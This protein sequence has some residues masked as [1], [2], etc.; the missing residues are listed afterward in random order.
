MIMILNLHDFKVVFS[1][2]FSAYLILPPGST[3]L[4]TS[5]LTAAGW[6]D[7]Y[8]HLHEEPGNPF[9]L[10]PVPGSHA[11]QVTWLGD[12]DLSS[13]L[14]G[15]LVLLH[16]Q[17]NT[18]TCVAFRIAGSSGMSGKL[19]SENISASHKPDYLSIVLYSSFLILV[20]VTAIMA[21]IFLKRKEGKDHLENEKLANKSWK[22]FKYRI[23]FT[24]VSNIARKIEKVKQFLKT[25]DQFKEKEKLKKEPDIWTTFSQAQEY[26][27]SLNNNL[28]FQW[29]NSSYHSHAGTTTSEQSSLDESFYSEN[30]VVDVA[31]TDITDTDSVDGINVDDDTVKL[32]LGNEDFVLSE[33]YEDAHQKIPKISS[34]SDIGCGVKVNVISIPSD[35]NFSY[36][37]RYDNQNRS[38]DNGTLF[39]GHIMNRKKN[40]CDITVVHKSINVPDMTKSEDQCGVYETISDN[41]FTAPRAVQYKSKNS[42]KNTLFHFSKN[43]PDCYTIHTRPLPPIP[44]MKR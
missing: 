18:E 25:D 20:Y 39:H 35:H 16:L 38:K 13:Y 32:K 9:T 26:Q 15:K 6:R 1:V 4:N 43:K 40:N 2:H 21:C 34:T 8:P 22:N 3:I 42:P 12:Q 14:A 44:P 11:T 17:K 27:Q 33:M 28:T 29:V 23:N 41:N 24:N 7:L 31:D 10:S 37:Q 36:N 5:I 19:E 30:D